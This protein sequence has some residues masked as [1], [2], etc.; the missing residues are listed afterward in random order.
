[1]NSYLTL[2]SG[3]KHSDGKHF[4]VIKLKFFQSLPVIIIA[5]IFMMSCGMKGR[6]TPDNVRNP[7]KIEIWL[8]TGD[9]ETR[10]VRQPDGMFG[11][12]SDSLPGIIID[13]TLKY[14]E[15]DGFGYT[16]TGG[17]AMLISRMDIAQRSALLNELFTTA[18]IGV[19]YL[20]IS[21][22]ASDLDEKVFSYSD[23]PEGDSD[24]LME[25]FTLDPDRQ[26]LIPVLKEILQ[27]FPELKIM[28]S[29]W[30][31]PLW[32]KTNGKSVGGSLKPEFYD[33]YARYFVRYIQEM[34]REGIHIDAVTVQNEPLHPGN[35]PSLLM[36]PHEQ[37]AFIRD[38][39][40]PAFEKEGI[41]TKIVI[42]D[43]NADRI[44]YPL[45]VLS[46]AKARQYIDGTAF[47]LYGGSIG[48]LSRVHEE[49]P[50]KH[51]YFTEQ[52]IGAPS[53]FGGDFR[54]HMREVIIGS[55][56]NWCRVA[57]EWNLAADPDQKPYTEG[58]CTRCLGAVTLD[59]NQVERNT[60][61]YII[62]HAARFVRPGSVRTGSSEIRGLPNVAFL[63][64]EGKIVL[65]VLN[66]KP[67]K[68]D[69]SVK[70]ND[71][72]FITSLEA[73]SAA[74]YVW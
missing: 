43:H 6:N 28:G 25:R 40:G 47:H 18:G 29:P 70:F 15:I 41:R 65:I 67:E 13:T 42:Y 32:M 1:M 71:R 54:W 59:G 60:A 66:D 37:A 74:T 3:K 73:G 48:A 12:T 52:W 9:G 27:I 38:N 31:P 46:D 7:E 36:L 20:R 56:R 50:D 51:L 11:E 30:S 72:V 63:N 64:P 24:P 55:M 8:T 33:A 4:P 21:I 26:Y 68:M 49:Y 39:L 53:D 17:S 62:A 22:G 35:N 19:S 58:G 34:A 44:D 10:F 61:W 14:Q 69:F 2:Y 5:L 57:L 45:E 23:L 16:L